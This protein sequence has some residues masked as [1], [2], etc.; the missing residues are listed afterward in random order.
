MAINFVYGLE[1]SII[2]E[3]LSTLNFTSDFN[4]RRLFA[5]ILVS[6]NSKGKYERRKILDFVKNDFFEIFEFL[7]FFILVFNYLECFTLLWNF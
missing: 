1:K 2:Y 3:K 4:G 5:Q 7:L 6:R